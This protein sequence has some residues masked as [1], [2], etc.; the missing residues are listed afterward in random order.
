MSDTSDG[1]DTVDKQRRRL[2]AIVSAAGAATG[3]ACVIPFAAS[4]APSDRAR[5]AGAPVEV[6][7]SSLN[8]GDII[9]VEW[10]GK[11]VWL[12]KRNQEMLDTLPQL[13]SLLED[14][15]SLRHGDEFT[16]PYCR[17]EHRSIKPE[18]LIVISICTHLGCIPSPR[19]QEGPQPSLPDDWKGGF[20]C[21]CHGS[22]YDLAGRVFLN[23]PA[24]D[25]LQIPPHH[26]KDDNTVIIG[27]APD[28][29]G[30]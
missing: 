1:R 2:I 26:Y 9:T 5:L 24:P 27:I 22:K 10:R 11:P 29:K 25:N 16:P 18:C 23:Q 30:S 20:L 28:E 8:Y 13:D 7:I 4:L 15:K 19:L 12:L 3:V 17:N 6:D 21:P 14:P